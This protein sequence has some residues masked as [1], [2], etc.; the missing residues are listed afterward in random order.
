MEI[1]EYWE[2]FLF[3][4]NKNAIFKVLQSCWNHIKVFEKGNRRVKNYIKIMTNS[5]SL[6]CE[7]YFKEKCLYISFSI[8]VIFL[9]FRYF[10]HVSDSGQMTTKNLGQ[11]KMFLQENKSLIFWKLKNNYGLSLIYP[12]QPGNC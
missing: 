7:V 3:Y 12:V 4:K 2:K 11:L 9:A 10:L 1:G 8:E 5:R 6:S